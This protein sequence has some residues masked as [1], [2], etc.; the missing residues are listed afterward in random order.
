MDFALYDH[1][2]LQTDTSVI[3]YVNILMNQIQLVKSCDQMRI[4]GLYLQKHRVRSRVLPS[5]TTFAGTL[6]KLDLMREDEERLEHSLE[7]A[8]L[9]GFKTFGS[10]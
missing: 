2:K 5:T 9:A 10:S 4:L 6:M 7:L 3:N 8:L 1:Q